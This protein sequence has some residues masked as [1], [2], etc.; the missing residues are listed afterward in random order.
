MTRLDD[1]I[2]FYALLDRLGTRVGGP[3]LLVNCHGRMDWPQRGVYFFFEEGE[4]RSQSGS[5]PRV[6]RVG[7]HALRPGSK[8]KL[9]GRLSQHRGTAKSGGG[10]HRGSIF[11]LLVGA[12]LMQRDPSLSVATW[13]VGNTAKGAIRTAEHGAE[14]QVSQVIGAMPFLWLVIDDAP[15]SQSLRGVVERGSIA[16]LS[17]SG[18]PP[19]DS[20][21]PSWLGKRCPRDRVVASDL[22]NQDHVEEEYDPGFLDVLEEL[23]ENTPGSERGH[24]A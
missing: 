6:V 22:W 23:V 8:T 4:A 3:R 16:L 2:R 13:G 5:G 14:V 18:K 21:S 24:G 19:L 15:G 17:N 20:A 11:R 10:S 1:L 9:W 12:S 7:T